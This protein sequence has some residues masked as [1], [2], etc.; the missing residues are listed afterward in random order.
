MPRTIINPLTGRQIFVGGPTF[1][2]LK[3]SGRYKDK[4]TKLAKKAK[5]KTLKGII[6]P[7]QTN[8]KTR[9]IKYSKTTS[10]RK[11]LD[12]AGVR[13]ADV[14]KLPGCGS[15]GKYKKSDGPFCGI[16]G[17][18]CERTFPVGTKKRAINAV[19]RSVNA[20]NPAGI[21]KCATDYALKKGWITKE[22]K[23]RLLAKYK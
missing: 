17:G 5:T 20:P 2:K 1:Q 9:K 13:L 6:F 3:E 22:D 23:K 19:V 15:L 11:N 7:G 8:L 10:L 21:R 4:V 16:Q 18:A 14:K 12:K